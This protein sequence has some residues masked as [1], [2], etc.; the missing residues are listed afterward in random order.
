MLA[1]SNHEMPAIV[2]K[3]IKIKI[4]KNKTPTDMTMECD[5]ETPLA[6][7]AN[8]AISISTINEVSTNNNNTTSG[9][10]RYLTITKR[11]LSPISKETEVNPKQKISKQE[12]NNQNRFAI[13]SA[14][15]EK[16]DDNQYSANN[17]AI[18]MPK[19][20]PPPI[21]IREA[22]NNK[23]I[24]SIQSCV[25]KNN[26]YVVDIK[27]GQL[28]ETK[29]QAFTEAYYCNIVEL[30]EKNNKQFYTYQLKS[31]KGL[32]V[33]IKGID[34][35]VDPADIKKDL[36]EQGFEVKNVVNIIN[37]FKVRQPMFKV[38]LTPEA[39]KAP[40]GKPHPI[41][42]VKYVLY[43]KITVEE[44]HKTNTLPQCQ[45]CQEYGHTKTYCKLASV[46]VACG[47]LHE[48]KQCNKDKKNSIYKKCSNCNGQ[49][50]ANYRGCPVYRHLINISSQPNRPPIRPMGPILS[51]PPPQSNLFQ[52]QKQNYGSLSYAEVIKRNQPQ[53]NLVNESDN[54]SQIIIML[55]T[56]MQQLAATVQEMQKTLIAQ[57]AILA[58]LAAP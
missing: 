23:L 5:G 4:K 19:P 20:R 42:N 48:T 24:E 38:E 10:K 33:V 12:V 22:S 9:I 39:S 32:K 3:P 50:T 11:K 43:R 30:L 31:A 28:S 26:F 1:T 55:V 15:N 8:D 27:R 7:T 47:E 41:Y 14:D 40:K 58:K 6:T 54:L 37:R 16:K 17:E 57:N 35:N 56:N 29:V 36:I 21:Y 2:K 34:H 46:C 51:N 25:G 49:H 53:S 45:N 52:A 44:P 13:L 18:S